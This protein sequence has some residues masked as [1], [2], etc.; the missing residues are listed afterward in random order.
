MD[1]VASERELSQL[2]ADQAKLARRYAAERNAYGEASWEVMVLLVPHQAEDHYRKAAYEK[3]LVMLLGD[4]PEAAE[5][6]K[7]LTLAQQRYKGLEKMLDQK[8]ARISSL[9]SL[10]RYARQND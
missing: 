10:M 8:A 7:R 6:V 5:P 4:C 3:Q 2:S 9:Q 1:F